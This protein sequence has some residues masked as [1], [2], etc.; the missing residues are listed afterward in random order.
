M[1]RKH[2]YVANWYRSSEVPSAECSE[3]LQHLAA[4]QLCNSSA[5]WVYCSTSCCSETQNLYST[6][7][8]TE[9]KLL[10]CMKENNGSIFEPIIH[11][12]FRQNVFF[13]LVFRYAPFRSFSLASSRLAASWEAK[14]KMAFQDQATAWHVLQHEAFQVFRRFVCCWK[15]GGE[16]DKLLRT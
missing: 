16:S 5:Y 7:K 13:I 10:I 15:L 6:V 11:A 2:K 14:L 9:I 3:V 1:E 4:A 8:K 12:F